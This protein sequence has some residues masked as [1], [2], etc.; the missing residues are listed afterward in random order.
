L[1][2]SLYPSEIRSSGVGLGMTMGRVGGILMSFLGGYLLDFAD[3][4]AAI[5]FSALAVCAM[6][7]TAAGWLVKDSI[8]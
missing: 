8:R 5:L 7:A 6:V 2:A 4:S 3:G 1:T